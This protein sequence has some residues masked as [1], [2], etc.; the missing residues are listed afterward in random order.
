MSKGRLE[1]S[2]DLVASKFHDSS[3]D[4]VILSGVLFYVTFSGVLF[5]VTFSGFQLLPSFVSYCTV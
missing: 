1:S 4:L 5:Y 3:G 2:G